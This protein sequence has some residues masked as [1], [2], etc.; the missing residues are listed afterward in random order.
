M[1]CFSS[2]AADEGWGLREIQAPEN[3]FIQFACA[4]NETAD[5]NLF[6]KYFSKNIT[7]ENVD[8]FDV[9]QDIE[10]IVRRESNGAQ[11]P[12]S[13]YKLPTDRIFYLNQV[14]CGTRRLTINEC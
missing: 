11:R 13:M 12:L 1:E 4:D 8:M 2:S 7:E 6:T 10:D 14:T 5:I 9:F 3:T